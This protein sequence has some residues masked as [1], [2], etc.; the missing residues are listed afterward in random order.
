MIHNTDVIQTVDITVPDIDIAIQNIHIQNTD[1]MIHN[2]DVIQTV[3]ITVPHIDIAIQNIHIECSMLKKAFTESWNSYSSWCATMAQNLTLLWFACLFK[4]RFY[5]E[6][7]WF[8][9]VQCASAKCLLV[10]D[11]HLFGSGD[12]TCLWSQREA[13]DVWCHHPV[14][15]L[16][17]FLCFP[18]PVSSLVFSALSSCSFCLVIFLLMVC[19][20]FFP[21]NSQTFF[22][23]NSSFFVWLSL[24]N[25]EMVVG[26][27]SSVP[28]GTG[29]F[30]YAFI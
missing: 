21:E 30:C 14:W 25:L 12:S 18:F 5:G 11:N 6:S 4:L 9:T 22:I 10:S 15:N 19:S 17:A 24:S 2:T 13:G 23:K 27:R 26:R 20:P 16:R 29:I 7:K 8:G 1:V 3:D 28:F